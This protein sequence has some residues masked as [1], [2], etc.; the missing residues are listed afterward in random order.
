MTMS[1]KEDL[2]GIEKKCHTNGLTLTKMRQRILSLLVDSSAPLSAYD[3]VNAYSDTFDEK[4]Q[5]MTVYRVLDY[6]TQENLAHRL[7]FNN[8]YMS[9]SKLS[10]CEAHGL[11]QFF[12]CKKCNKVHESPLDKAIVE[13]IHNRAA[14]IGH[15]VSV[16]HVEI[17]GICS[18]CR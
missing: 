12:I 11:S 4:I 13:L 15:E 16:P 7:N 8:K 18:A 10:C 3:L 17:E 9:C 14:E 5:A 1:C 6:L 2:L